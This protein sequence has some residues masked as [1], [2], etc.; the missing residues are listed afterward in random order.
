MEKYSV[1]LDKTFDKCVKNKNQGAINAVIFDNEKILYKRF[2]G[3]LDKKNKIETKEDSLFMIGSNTKVLTSLGIFRLLE[4]GVL[5]LD[6]PI[7]KFIP[8]F[9]V[10]SRIGDYTPTIENLLMHRAGIQCDLYEF[11]IGTKHSYTDIIE[12]LKETYLTSIPGTMFSYSNL[13]YTLLGIIEER[14]SGKKYPEFLQ[15]VLFAPLGMEV[16]FSREQDLPKS[17][18]NRVARSFNGKGKQVEDTLGILLPAGSNT[19]T[20]VGSLVKIGQLLMND[21]TVDG[22][23]LYKPET[24]QLMKTLKI[25]DDLDKELA[26][27]GYGLFHHG[28]NLD[29]KTGRTLGHGGDTLYHHSAFDFLP[30]EKIGVIV[31]TNF[32]KGSG[33]SRKLRADLFNAYLKE[34]GFDK[35]EDV[36]EEYISF[37]PQNYVGQYDS[38]LGP[39]ELT[40]SDKGELTTVL[41]KIPMTLKLNKDG[42]LVASPKSLL[43]KAT[44]ISKSLKGLKVKPATY[45]GRDVLLLEQK[46]VKQA[47]ADKHKEPGVNSEWLKALGSYK[48]IGK[49]YK[50]VISKASLVLKKGTIILEA[51]TEGSKLQYYLDVV[52]NREATVLGFG[53]NTN[54]TI[55]LTKKDGKYTLSFDGILATQK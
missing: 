55:F 43:I 17:L 49:E 27:I 50:E 22:V 10:K 45:F 18:S 23:Q 39:I 34:A 36:K 33:L 15:D 40:I 6:D 29:Y 30:D 14:A 32:E 20:T 44:P 12:G 51:N 31:Y 19:Y 8:E 2:S 48:I 52:N 54:Q 5:N 1:A 7:T 46:G 53:R 16:Y 47:L 21:G 24:I 42:W 4:D 3:Y 28:L 41:Q 11:I 35:K 25:N 38:L 13:G 26:V 37:I 9:S